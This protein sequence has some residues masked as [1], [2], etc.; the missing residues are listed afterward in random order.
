MIGFRKR[1]AP[2][3]AGILLACFAGCGELQPGKVS[4]KLRFTENGKE[5]KLP[6][7]ISWTITFR[8][9]EGKQ[10]TAKVGSDLSFAADNVPAGRVKIAVTGNALGQGGGLHDAK[11][12]ASQ[13]PSKEAEFLKKLKNYG[14]PDTS[15]IPELI[16]H[17]GKKESFDIT[18][19]LQ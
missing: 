19:D 17:S 7:T 1:L 14:D 18:V 13:P 11:N 2:I 16:V 6:S 5:L 12:P 4:G 8:G 15:K 3:L 10:A 9:A